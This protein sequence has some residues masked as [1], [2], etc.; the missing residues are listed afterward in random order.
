VYTPPRVA[1]ALSR[2]AV[3][4]AREVVVDPACGAGVFLA[5]VRARLVDLGA[6]QP[7][8]IGVDIDAATAAQAGAVCADFFGWV[9]SAQQVDAVVGNPPFIRSHL[10]PE[11]SRALAFAAMRR[12]GLCPSRLMSTW[13]PFL[14]LGCG[15]VKPGGRLAMVVPEE[16]LAV[17]YADELRQFLLRHFHR[18]TVCFPPGSIFPAV[19][20][21]VVLLL[22]E[23][24]QSGATGLFTAEFSALEEGLTEPSPP[25]LPWTWNGKWTHLFLSP[26]E[27]SE[28][29]ALRAELAWQPFSAYG[30]VE[31]GVVTGDNDYF[32][33]DRPAAARFA[34]RH[35]VPILAAARD[36]RGIRFGAGDFARLLAENRPAFLLHVAEPLD[37]LS[38]AERAYVD[39][40]QRQGVAERYKCRIRRPWYAVPGVRACHAVL[41]RQAGEM[42]RLVH[43]A[44][45]CTTTD[46][47]H[48]V[49]WRRPRDG[50]RHTAGFMNSWT[51]LAA[52]LTGRSY[53]GGVLEL[54][55]GEANRLP[56]PPPLPALDAVFDEAD[57]LVRAKQLSAAVEAVDGVVLSRRLDGRRRR[58]LRQTLAKLIARR[59]TRSRQV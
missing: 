21:A 42:P 58:D 11:D 17:G 56:L 6:G 18:V 31:V 34:R 13:A 49:T 52:E 43:L 39:S 10:F 27:R 35:L 37:E 24:E 50:K 33:L 25:S 19:Q 40:G 7:Q 41:L 30:R 5:A 38:E 57:T 53:G 16:L 4:S 15:L 59:T 55:P 14:A 29:E 9:G 23:R 54:M 44:K 20:Q 28:I 47:L 32:L 1:A 51:L 2:W 45:R 26:R 36:L 22:C 12:M 3:R 46:T 8:C 48:R